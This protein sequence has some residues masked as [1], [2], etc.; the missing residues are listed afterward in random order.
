MAG[1]V[2]FG[3]VSQ[4]LAPVLESELASLVAM[5]VAMI[6]WRRLGS[7]LQQ[8]LTTRTPGNSELQSGIAAANALI[9][10]Y[11]RGQQKR[12]RL[13]RFW[14][15]GLLQCFLGMTL[16]LVLYVLIENNIISLLGL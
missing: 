16:V 4:L 7:I 8:H 6:Y 1:G 11:H 14:N 15:A 12:G 5:L 3:V 9:R 10:Q 13:L 2:I